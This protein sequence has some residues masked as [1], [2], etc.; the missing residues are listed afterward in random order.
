MIVWAGGGT[1]CAVD[2][3]VGGRFLMFGR[4]ASRDDGTGPSVVTS[5]MCSGSRAATESDVGFLDDYLAGKTQ[6][7]ISGRVLQSVSSWDYPAYRDGSPVP[8]AE[9]VLSNGSERIT[10]KSTSDGTFIFVPVPPGEYT[11]SASLLPFTPFVGRERV[12]VPK[13]TSDMSSPNC[14]QTRS[15]RGEYSMIRAHP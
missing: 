5:A 11:I 12:S 2:Y 10:V 9:V 1:S 13:G 3:G 15:S 4:S 8:G 14:T 6:T 7:Y